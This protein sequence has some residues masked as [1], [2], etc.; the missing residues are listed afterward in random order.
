MSHGDNGYMKVE[1]IELKS[2][3]HPDTLTDLCAEACADA[4]DA[5]Y[6][7]KYGR[8]LHY[9]VDK[10]LFLAGNAVINYG[11]GQ[12][13][14]KPTFILGGQVSEL[15]NE[16]ADKLETTI[17]L[18]VAIYLPNL[19]DFK[20][21]IRCN[22]VSTNLADIADKKRCNDTSFGV[23]YAPLSAAENAVL[24]INKELGT[25]VWEHRNNA[26]DAVPLG[27]LWKI[28]YTPKHIFISAPLY[29]QET[30]CK[31][32]YEDSHNVIESRLAKYGHVVHN[33]DFCQGFPYMTLTGS[34]IEC[35]DDGQCGRGNRYNGLI[36]PCRPMTMECY[37]G[38]N[39]M[40]HIGKIY[41]KM[42][43]ERANALFLKAGKP[44]QVILVGK[45]GEPIEDYEEYVQ[46]L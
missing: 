41:Q 2:N 33:P 5:Y 24:D 12:I 6:Q 18:T 32:Q 4:L 11:G 27:E 28:M 3:G 29:A 38:K 13:L 10:A 9:N 22:N 30:H 37:W 40:N 15:E 1:I 25:M 35:G 19:N 26:P 8:I 34:S 23:G 16:L 44:V 39:N 42:A 46:E 7:S 43:H 14:K 31:E 17:R 36:T 20:V 21:E 45:I